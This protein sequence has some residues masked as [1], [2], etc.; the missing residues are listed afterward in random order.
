MRKSRPVFDDH[1][2]IIGAIEALVDV[3]LIKQ[4]RTEIRPS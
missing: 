1:K 3:S 4:A 2:Q